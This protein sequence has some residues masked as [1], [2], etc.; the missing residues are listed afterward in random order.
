MSKPAATTSEGILTWESR[1][2]LLLPGPPI[3]GAILITACLIAVYMSFVWLF[4]L[5]AHPMGF[6]V[7][8]LIGYILMVPRYVNYHNLIDRQLYVPGLDA[9]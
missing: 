9:L 8:L 2:A 5:T 6:L 1:L 4:V 3:I 7:P